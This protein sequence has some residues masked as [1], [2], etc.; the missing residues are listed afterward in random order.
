MMYV[1]T[2]LATDQCDL[3]IVDVSCYTSSPIKLCIQRL[4]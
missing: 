4:W 1:A 3:V 2:C